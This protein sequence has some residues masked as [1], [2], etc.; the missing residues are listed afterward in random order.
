MVEDGLFEKF[1]VDAVFGMHNK[2]G[3]P[4]GSFAIRP[5]P[6]LASSGMFEIVVKGVGSHAAHPHKGKDAVL[7]AGHIITAIQ[8]L[9]RANVPPVDSAVVSITQM[10]GGETWNV[11]PEE[12]VL[13]GTARF[14]KE[15]VQVKV[16]NAMRMMVE[17][18]AAA[19]GATVAFDYQRRYP[20]LINHER[21]AELAAQ[22]A[23]EIVGQDMVD[24][25]PL[26]SMAAEDFSFMLQERP[27]AYIT[28]G[29]G[30]GEG[31]FYL[32]NPRYIFNDE[33]LPY[34]ASYWVRLAQTFLSA[35][36]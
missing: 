20:P 22:V 27:G 29:N 24:R 1:A 7:I 15:E 8:S 14:F 28:V 32:H 23:A 12:V 6:M 25:D 35:P 36:R 13:R 4:I 3:V 33:A 30:A 26:P 10:H 2:P 16:E 9:V 21:E 31:E 11:I 5:G 34:G 17:H 18:I 19:Y